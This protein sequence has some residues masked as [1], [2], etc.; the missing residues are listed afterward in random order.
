MSASE[1]PAFHEVSRTT[2]KIM[3]HTGKRHH[4]WNRNEFMKEM[5]HVKP[6]PYHMQL[7]VY[8]LEDKIVPI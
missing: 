4:E 5:R 2:N 1:S 7:Y 3:K 8:I 6:Q